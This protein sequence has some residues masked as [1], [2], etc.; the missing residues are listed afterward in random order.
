M[1]SALVISIQLELYLLL[2]YEEFDFSFIL[3]Q[4]KYLIIIVILFPQPHQPLFYAIWSDSTLE[5][6]PMLL[7]QPFSTVFNW[8]RV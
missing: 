7:V 8:K 3:V 2:I 5:E 1:I 6:L 4:F